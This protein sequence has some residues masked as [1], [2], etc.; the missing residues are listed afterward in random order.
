MLRG[1]FVNKTKCPKCGGKIYLDSDHYGWFEACLM[2]GYTRN[3]K[4]VTEVKVESG[5]KYVAE[6]S[7]TPAN[8]K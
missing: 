5:D 8:P 1:G 6:N 3:L 2:C 4:K 7:V